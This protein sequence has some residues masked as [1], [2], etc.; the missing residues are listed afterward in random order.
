MVKPLAIRTL[1]CVCYVTLALQSISASGGSASEKD[2]QCSFSAPA[3]WRLHSTYRKHVYYLY[4][5]ARGEHPNCAVGVSSQIGGASLAS[6]Q[7]EAIARVRRIY[8]G[9][10]P[11]VVRRQELQSLRGVRI[12][13]AEARFDTY[14]QPGLKRGKGLP[15]RCVIYTCRGSLPERI[16]NLVCYP[17]PPNG[18]FFDQALDDMAK[19]ISF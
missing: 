13:K 19:S 2:I 8:S 16:Y 18:A 3:G 12:L 9:P 17:Q 5:T 1:S 7:D 10:S 6:E 14:L 11:P 15:V 4:E